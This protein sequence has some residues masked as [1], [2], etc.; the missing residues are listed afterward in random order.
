[1]NNMSLMDHNIL[2]NF[3]PYQNV[4]KLKFT[5]DIHKIIDSKMNAKFYSI[6]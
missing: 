5:I 4:V 2:L 6:S 3:K 1:M